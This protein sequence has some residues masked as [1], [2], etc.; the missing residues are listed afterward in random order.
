V[1]L[2][3]QNVLTFSF[4]IDYATYF[5]DDEQIISSHKN[6]KN[7]C[8]IPLSHRIF[9][10]YTVKQDLIEIDAW[11]LERVDWLKNEEQTM[12]LWNVDYED[13]VH[14]LPVRTI[15]FEFYF[16]FSNVSDA[17]MFKMKFC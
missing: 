4:R 17:V 1:I 6:V 15:D 14:I 8:N 16:S 7:Y 13:V 5:G 12:G 2:N 3:H 10:K 9:T 11:L